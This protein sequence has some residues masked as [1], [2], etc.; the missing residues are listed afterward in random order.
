M[1]P[2]QADQLSDFLLAL[3][4]DELILGHRAS[5]WCGH[6]PI[7]E[8]D[9]AFANLALDEIGH[10]VVWYTLWVEL[11]GGKPYRSPDELVYTRNSPA[12]RCSQLVEQPNGDWAFS[13]LRQYLFDASEMI[14]LQA[15][16]KSS[17]TPL[18]EASAKI[19]NEER[20][21]LRHTRAWV[22]RLSL[23]TEHSHNRMQAALDLIWPRTFQLFYWTDWDDE[24]S[25]HGWIP[26]GEELRREW[27]AEVKPF[28]L[29]CSL[30]LI[31]SADEVLPRTVHSA[32]FKPLITELQS[33]AR[34]DPEA[35][36]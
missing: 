32:Y 24:L 18:Q 8:E 5:E 9:I 20:Y 30:D 3:G 11:T 10:A 1:K 34:L 31:Q 28:L 6:G 14:R 23:G 25:R 2:S 13:M 7:L 12:W 17:Y 35:T 22:E 27:E 21:H 16:G 19:Q 26:K 33:V 29:H 4:D 36:W 15:L